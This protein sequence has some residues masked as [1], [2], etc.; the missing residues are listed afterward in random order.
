MFVASHQRKDD[1]QDLGSFL[2]YSSNFGASFS[3]VNQFAQI[4]K[5]T[6]VA[7]SQ[8]G[9]RV[10]ACE[11]EAACWTSNDYGTTFVERVSSGQLPWVAATM[12]A[13]GV[14]QFAAAKS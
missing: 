6:A 7:T 2:L 10:L 14:L 4:R 12:S 5:W 9:Q 1:P 11:Y 3:N 13:D 8:T